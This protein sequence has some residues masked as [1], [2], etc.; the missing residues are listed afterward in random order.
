[1]QSLKKKESEPARIKA[2]FS[3]DLLDKIIL[4][5]FTDDNPLIGTKSLMRMKEFFSIIDPKSYEGDPA[6]E[7]RVYLVRKLLKGLLVKK[8][9]DKAILGE[10]A[11]G[12]KYDDDIK[13]IYDEIAEKHGTITDDVIDFIN[14]FVADRLKFSYLLRQGEKIHETT[15]RLL[16]G[17]YA[18]LYDIN[19]EMETVLTEV[20]YKIN[21]VK[22]TNQMLCRDFDNGKE[23]LLK[24]VRNT[25]LDLN[26]RG[27]KI[28]TGIQFLN[29]MLGGGF[30]KTR[31][32][33]FLGV[34]KSWKSGLL[35]NIALW[36]KKYNKDIRSTRGKRPCV[37]YLTQEN[38]TSE[39]LERV[40]SYYI[41]DKSQINEFRPDVAAK[42]LEEA[43]LA[44]RKELA[45]KIKYRPN[46]SINVNDIEQILDELELEGFECVLL[47]HDYLKRLNSIEKQPDLR[48]RFGD[49][50]NELSVLAK[51]RDIPIVTA[52]QLNREAYRVIEAATNENKSNIARKLGASQIGE[53]ALIL[54]NVDMA[55]VINKE[56]KASIKKEYLTIKNIASRIK[57]SKV[58]YFA[59]EFE[60]GMRLVEDADLPKPLSLE[61]LG[62][63]LK[64]YG[65]DK[66]ENQLNRSNS[67]P[68]NGK[69]RPIRD[70]ARKDPSMELF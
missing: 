41:G 15:S 54:E 55:F 67:A 44:D 23:E 40:W 27:N 52:S 66:L 16:S 5:I 46:G 34:P 60:N 35:L 2:D 1:M 45:L 38:T 8:I 18:S 24:A 22:E 21:K 39:T 7:S 28:R 10:Y 32:Y 62:D 29:N 56:F 53:S 37:L 59:H 4:Y 12:G 19:E 57:T 48:I 70:G 20:V 61:D 50:I 68:P 9:S 17:D 3:I 6:I 30:Q 64:K 65:E 31:V 49:I 42:M 43:G 25:I 11:L 58:S 26:K 14:E 13:T 51:A 36:A 47:V 69:P 63:D 33:C